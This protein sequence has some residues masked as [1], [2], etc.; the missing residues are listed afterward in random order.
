MGVKRSVASF[1]RVPL[2][3]GVRTTKRFGPGSSEAA[4]RRS[5]TAET[6]ILGAGGRPAAGGGTVPRTAAVRSAL[7]ANVS[8]TLDVRRKGWRSAA[9]AGTLRVRLKAPHAVM[10]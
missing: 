9:A 5:P 1:G 6:S 2:L 7:A 4:V 8:S 10:Q 3:S